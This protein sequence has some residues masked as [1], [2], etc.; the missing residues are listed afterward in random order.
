MAIGG[1]IGVGL[2]LGAGSAISE[3]GPAV[4]VCYA[5]AGGIVFLIL[6]ALGEMVLARPASG[7]FA[8]HAETYIGPWAG[9]ATGWTYW[10]MWVTTVMAEITAIGIYVQYFWSDVPQWLPAFIAV[11]VLLAANLM[12][13]R[14]FGEV[15]FWFALIKVLAIILF[16]L[17]G[18]AIILLAVG[19]LG[20]EA[21]FTNLTN[22]GGFFPEGVVGPLVALQIVTYAF[23]GVEMIGIAAGEAKEPKRTVPVAINST[24]LR[25]LIFYVGSILIILALIPWDQVQNTEVSPFVLAF[26]SVGIAGAAAILNVVILTAALSSCNTGVFTTGRMLYALAGVG[27][28]PRHFRRLSSRRVP[29]TALV[30][31]AAVMM[32]GVVVNIVVPKDAF[33]YITSVA[34][35]GILWT[36]GIILVAHLRFRRREREAGRAGEGAF[37]MPGAPW[38]NFAGFVFLGTVTVLLALDAQQRVAL[39]AGAAWAVVLAVGWSL[40]KRRGQPVQQ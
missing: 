7:G 18:L 8:T 38:T 23:I 2:F 6:R 10:L 3:A 21:S 39:Y 34:T 29:A 30:A 14:L 11:L 24:A 31:S 36:W 15:E 19:K 40:L 4:L 27:E 26:D 16:I 5:V 13:V 1:A 12:S 33:E 37:R 17:V 9:F 25:I 22:H 32:V 28:A 35:V 20:G